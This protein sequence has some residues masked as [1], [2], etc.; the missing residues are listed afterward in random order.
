MKHNDQNRHSPKITGM[1]DD[2]PR[3][4]S[5]VALA[6]T[7]VLLAAIVAALLLIPSP[8]NSGRCIGADIISSLF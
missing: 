6:I 7:I 4:L 2:L 3:K 8:Y 1:I 5:R